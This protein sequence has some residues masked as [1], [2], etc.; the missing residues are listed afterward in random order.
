MSSESFSVPARVEVEVDDGEESSSATFLVKVDS[1]K[2]LVQM[3]SAVWNM[4]KDQYGVL[5]VNQMGMRVSVETAAKSMHASAYMPLEHFSTF[6][7]PMIRGEAT[8]VRLKVNL[9]MLLGCLAVY[10]IQTLDITSLVATFTEEDRILHLVL[11]QG[12]VATECDM[13]TVDVQGTQDYDAAFRQVFWGER[14]R[15]FRCS[16]L[17]LPLFSQNS[18]FDAIFPS[19]AV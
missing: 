9:S 18:F 7:L 3:I 10:G 11:E 12:G 4:K 15:Q 17:F 5:T 2:L 13:L 14:S 1:I 8:E 6:S 16:C 19:Q